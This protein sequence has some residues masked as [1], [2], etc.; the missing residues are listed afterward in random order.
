[1]SHEQ[2]ISVQQV[3]PKAYEP[4]F[5]LERYIRSGN[6]DKSLLSL[7]KVR[8]SEI[9]GC[10]YCLDMH[11]REAR[12]AGV[13]QRRLDVLSAWREA[14]GLFSIREQAA[15]AFSEE[16]TLIGKEG[17]TDRAWS[18]LTA[19]FDQQEIVYL[20]MAIVAINAWNRLAVSVHQ[21]LPDQA[22]E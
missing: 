5:A 11:A 14:P 8:A 2:R 13:D 6:L 3:D 18:R 21:S 4:I 22:R 15:L 17:V 12:A 10:A 16:V 1:M 7:I 19:S 20:L 9:N